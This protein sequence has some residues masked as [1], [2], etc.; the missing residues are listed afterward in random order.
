MN[1]ATDRQGLGMQDGGGVRGHAK[2]WVREQW[3][4]L[5]SVQNGPPPAPSSPEGAARSEKGR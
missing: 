4:G 3:R 2:A 5:V 1:E